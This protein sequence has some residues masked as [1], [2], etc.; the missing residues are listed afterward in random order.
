MFDNGTSGPSGEVDRGAG[1]G[2]RWFGSGTGAAAGG[3]R[4]PAT[5]LARRTPVMSEVAEAVWEAQSHIEADRLPAAMMALRGALGTVTLD[6]GCPAP[7]VADAARLYAGVLITLGESY[8]ALLYST[9]AHEATR[10][11][12]KPTS[13][14]ALQADLIHAFVLRATARLG[15][16]VTLYRDAV[17][18]LSQ[19]F[20]PTGRPALAARAD[21]AV[22]LHAAGMCQEAGKTLHRTYVSHREAFGEGDA[23]GI[24]MLTRLGVMARDCGG[25]EL[26]HQYFDE[27]KALCAEHFS[28]TDP[29]S[30]HV[31][32]ATRAGSD[33]GHTC[34][35]PATSQQGI[36]ARDL[37]VSAFDAEVRDLVVTALD[38]DA[39]DP[40]VSAVE[41]V[42]SGAPVSLVTDASL[43]DHTNLLF[44]GTA[45]HIAGQLTID[46]S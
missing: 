21:L 24:R 15:E 7:D 43:V 9:Y 29:L 14:R 40:L 35:H 39:T 8:S 20:G 5:Q 45:G 22:A 1:A 32:G 33:A 26:A 19:R 34:G 37:F 17:E 18:R 3:R 4:E 36:D 23:Q 44:S 6:P 27:A 30:R 13:L 25:F 41:L 11:L 2:S 31:T 38:L 10:L 28:Y 46:G 12:D 42:T 16:S